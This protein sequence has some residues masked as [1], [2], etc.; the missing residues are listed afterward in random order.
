MGSIGAVSV[1]YVCFAR[2][3]LRFCV[4]FICLFNALDQ[5]NN[6]L[7]SRKREGSRPVKVKRFAALG[8]VLGI[9]GIIFL[10]LG[11]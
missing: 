1:L 9:I 2:T 6:I 3:C 5:C 7:V 8:S 10:S 11:H 4:C